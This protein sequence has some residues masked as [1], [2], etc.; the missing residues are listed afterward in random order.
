[1]QR[2]SLLLVLLAAAAAHAWVWEGPE[3]EARDLEDDTVLAILEEYLPTAELAPRMEL[4]RAHRHR[5]V[6][7]PILS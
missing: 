7:P 3:W 4:V 1:M 2:Y 5:S 6:A